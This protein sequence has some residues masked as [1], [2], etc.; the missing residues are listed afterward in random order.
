MEEKCSTFARFDLEKK[1]E[2]NHLKQH[3]VACWCVAGSSGANFVET[4]VQRSGLFAWLENL[5][6]RHR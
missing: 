1:K 4:V 3:N 5:S 2:K 6:S